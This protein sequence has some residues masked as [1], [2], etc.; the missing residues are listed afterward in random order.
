MEVILLK[1]VEKLGKEGIIVKV[2][3]GYAQNYLIPRGWA[4]VS[5]KDNYKRLSELKQKRVKFQEQEKN[6]FLELKEKLDKVSITIT[7][8]VKDNDEIYGSISE[9][10]ILKLLGEEGIKLSKGTII[11]DEPLKKLGVFTLRV[12]LHSE[13][14]ASLRV[15]IV[16]K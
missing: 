1:D 6:K 8:Q 14:E 13:I 5:T 12:A 15:W 16:K 3:D 7:S 2:K 10:Q 4:L 11:L 9:A